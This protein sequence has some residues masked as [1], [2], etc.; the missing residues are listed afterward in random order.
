MATSI[1]ENT[2][3]IIDQAWSSFCRSNNVVLWRRN[4]WQLEHVVKN[5]EQSKYKFTRVRDLFRLIVTL[6]LYSFFPICKLS[7]CDSCT[8]LRKLLSHNQRNFLSAQPIITPVSLNCQT[9]TQSSSCPPS[10]FSA[11]SAGLFCFFYSVISFFFFNL[12]LPCPT[13]R[14][15]ASGRVAC[16]SYEAQVSVSS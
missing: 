9:L 14:P 12:R 11:I 2:S 16:Q 13:L 5:T 3:P 4:H 7:H 15:V 6:F 8:A 1:S 10:I